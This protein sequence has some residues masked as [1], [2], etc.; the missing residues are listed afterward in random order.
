MSNGNLE[1]PRD[2]KRNNYFT[3]QFLVEA[4]FKNEQ[5]YHRQMR[6]LHNRALH[7]WGIADGLQVTRAGQWGVSVTAGLAIDKNGREIIVPETQTQNL[8]NS[9]RGDVFLVLSY[10][11]Q[12]S[13]PYTGTGLTTK[14]TRNAEKFKLEFR[15]TAPDDGTVIKLVKLTLDA[16]GIVN[17]PDTSVR[18]LAGS[19]RRGNA[20]GANDMYISEQGFIGIG[21]TKPEEQL[22][23]A[24]GGYKIAMGPTL[25]N[26]YEG[27]NH[28]LW[29]LDYGTAYLGFNAV[30]TNLGW[31]REDL[32]GR[33]ASIIYHT[34]DG[35]LC[36]VTADGT[37]DEYLS[38]A[39]IVARK[40][41]VI[42]GSGLVRFSRGTEPGELEISGWDSGWSINAKKDQKHLFLN[43]DAQTNSNVLIGQA[44]K[45]LLV[46]GSDGNVGI[47]TGI[48]ATPLHVTSRFDK[49]DAVTRDVATFGSSDAADGL[50]LKI[51]V[52][53]GAEAARRYV[54]LQAKEG[55]QAR[56]FMLQSEGG[57]VAIGGAPI[58]PN[59]QQLRAA[60]TDTLNTAQTIQVTMQGWIPEEHA[61]ATKELMRAPVTP[62]LTAMEAVKSA[63]AEATAV[64]ATLTQII[65]A[66]LR[67][68]RLAKSAADQ[69][70]PTIARFRTFFATL[71]SNSNPTL[72]AAGQKSLDIADAVLG[73]ISTLREKTNLALG[74]ARALAAANFETAKFFIDGDG[75]VGGSLNCQGN[76]RASKVGIGTPPVESL[77]VSG[78][79]CLSA[80]GNG[81]YWDWPG[82]TIEQVI[83][84]KNGVVI[85]FRN[86]MR[87][88]DEGNQYGGFDFADSAGK[89]MMRIYD[90]NVYARN[91]VIT[92]LSDLAEDYSSDND[93]APG[94]VVCLKSEREGIVRSENPNDVMALGVISTK[95]GFRLNGSGEWNSEEAESRYPVA[96]CGRVPCKVTDENGPIARGDVLTTSS[97]P[98]HA[99]KAKPVSVNGVDFYHPGTIIGKAL[100]P[101]CC[102]KGAIEVFVTLR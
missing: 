19:V 16:S 24:G 67:T 4:D 31:R 77:T 25:G 80:S 3:S 90:E 36:F 23:I 87:G 73:Q 82:R 27:R 14:F 95:P 69:A 52:K 61:E 56:P 76:L 64:G 55:D 29:D 43:R 84:D 92:P 72:G 86:S 34:K 98:G 75:G 49:T 53:G 68:E 48:P 91:A 7:V 74:H 62:L 21:T 81:I 5:D 11:D 88:G 65:E 15:P 46:R 89:S 20:L 71:K 40:R 18:R 10:E 33:G 63:A 54:A 8:P 66:T 35:A 101:H 102:G 12:E 59:P 30:R 57:V 6:H 94:D 39:E 60:V 47:G 17:D 2:I 96:L 28:S 42:D 22:Q 13:D 83:N 78:K 100:E 99:M 37:G 97:T 38:A 70:E 44:S 79:I 32:Y 50:G 85:R 93:L 45:E 9:M 41:M 26:G 1:V 51:Q 58:V